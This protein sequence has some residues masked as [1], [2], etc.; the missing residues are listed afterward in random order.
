MAQDVLLRVRLLTLSISTLKSLSYNKNRRPAE[1]L[2]L[3][4]VD[5]NGFGR[6]MSSPT[7]TIQDF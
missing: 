4:Q 6:N 2:P 3:M 5:Q 1:I 7:A